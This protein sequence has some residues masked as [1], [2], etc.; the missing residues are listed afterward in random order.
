MNFLKI[1]LFGLAEF[2]NVHRP[3]LRS[4]ARQKKS[5]D[6]DVIWCTNADLELG[7]SHVTKCSLI[8]VSGVRMGCG[9]YNC[10]KQRFYSRLISSES[11]HSAVSKCISLAIER[12]C[13][14]VT[15]TIFRPMP[16]G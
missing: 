5:S 16:C 10:F 14:T 13:A 7:D 3:R 9:V 2:T 8:N 12:A 11:E 6:F 15:T 4:I 1:C